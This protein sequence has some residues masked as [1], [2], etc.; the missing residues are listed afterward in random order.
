VFTIAREGS[1]ISTTLEGISTAIG[2]YRTPQDLRECF[3]ELGL[4][5]SD[6]LHPA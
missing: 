3:T 4:L 5:S 1:E 2:F 6:G